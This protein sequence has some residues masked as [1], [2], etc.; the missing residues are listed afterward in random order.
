[1]PFQVPVASLNAQSSQTVTL[2]GVVFRLTFTFNTRCLAWDMTI[3]EQDGT[4]LVSGIKLLPQ[5]DLL[6][7]HKDVRL[8]P[9]RLLAVDQQEADVAIRPLK[10]ELG[11]KLVLVYFTEADINAIIST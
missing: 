4:V 6:N 7:R 3:A 10:S 11:S 9:G 5:L 2:D 8:P 1:M